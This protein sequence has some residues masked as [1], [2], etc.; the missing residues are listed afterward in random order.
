MARAAAARRY[1]KALFALAARDGRVAEVRAELDALRQRD[2]PRATSSAACCSSRSIPR[3]ERRAVLAAVAERARRGPAA[4]ELLVLPGR[5][6]PPGGLRRN[7]D[8]FGRLA[9]EAA[10]L[11]AGARAER[12]PAER[13]AARA[14]P[15]RARAEERRDRSSSRSR[16]IPTLL[17]GVVAQLGDLVYDGSLRTQLAQLRASLARG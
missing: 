11:S 7:R 2:S 3:R 9:D 13:G 1:A 16:S 17:G 8:E 12:E 14:A 10:G 6:A 15:A 5:P 4:P